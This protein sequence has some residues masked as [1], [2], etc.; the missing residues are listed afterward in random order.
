MK[1]L[2]LDQA[3]SLDYL[4]MSEV[5]R[6][7]PGPGEIRVKVQAVGLNPVD[8]K[9]AESGHPDWQFPFILGLDVAGIVDRVGAGV[10]H[11]KIGDHV[12]Y[13]GN[14]S[15]PG[16]YAEWAINVAHTAAPLPKGLS[17]TEAAALP[18]AAFTAYQALYRKLHI[19]K[20]QTILIE[21]GAGGVG[22]YAIQLARKEGLLVITTCRD[23]NA[24][25]A[26]EL[27]AH[28]CIDYTRT[29]K[30]AKIM[31]ITEGRGLDCILDTVSGESATRNLSLLAFN[32]GI[33]SLVDLPDSKAIVPF[34]K[35]VSIHEVALG[36]AYLSKDRS[37]QDDLGN[38]ARELGEL[39]SA[40]IVKPNVHEVISLESVPQALKRLK[41]R[42]VVRG[43]IV[44]RLED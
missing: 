40:G 43:K 35:A 9:V 17:Y 24:D 27:G 3:G 8:Y 6:P 19:K 12:Y 1:A 10:E 14:L 4:R 32:G 38:I 21:G 30:F 44:A 31:D 13:H 25:Y 34:E 18:C 20:G 11:W 2:V 23:D 42:K 41:N 36:G 33:A 16:G 26:K 28:F 7:E 37:A 22:G 5:N 15:R 29:D 39:A